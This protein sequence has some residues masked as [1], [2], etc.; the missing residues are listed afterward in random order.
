MR[1]FARNLALLLALTAAGVVLRWLVV[2][3]VPP[4]GG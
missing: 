1:E 2:R 4:W 3:Y